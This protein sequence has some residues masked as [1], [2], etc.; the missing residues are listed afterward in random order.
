VST[1]YIDKASRAAAAA[2]RAW[3]GPA[4]RIVALTPGDATNIEVA[5][6]FAGTMRTDE[7]ECVSLASYRQAGP[8]AVAA[9]DALLSR[10]PAFAAMNDRLGRGTLRL[11]LIKRC[12]SEIQAHL[13]RMLAAKALAGNEARLAIMRPTMLRPDSIAGAV[14]GLAVRHYQPFLHSFRWRLNAAR[15]LGGV[16]L[17][18]TRRR[19]ARSRGATEIL[20]PGR[21]AV[22]V[23][24]EDVLSHDRT[25]R[26]QPHWLTPENAD[27]Q[28]LR[29]FILPTTESLDGAG[30]RELEALGAHPLS[31]S[32]LGALESRKTAAERAIG[33]C[34]WQARR[35]LLSPHSEVVTSSAHVLALLDQAK[36]IVRCIQQLGIGCLVA[37]DPHLVQA[38]AMAVAAELTGVPLLGYQYSNLAQF[39]PPMCGTAD[40][41]LLFAEGFEPVWNRLGVRPKK[42]APNGYPYDGAFARV[43]NR[44]LALRD[45]LRARGANTIVCYFD[46]SVQHDRFGIFNP[47][48]QRREIFALLAKVMAEPDWGLVVKSQ[49]EFNSPSRLF[50][51]DP[52]L[53]QA[54]ATGRYV[55]LRRGEHRNVVFP[56]EAAM[57]ADI[58]I[59]HMVGATAPLEAALAGVRSIM[60]DGFNQVRHRRELYAQ[61]P[62]VYPNVE[63]AITAIERWRTGDPAA[64]N[65]GDWTPILDEM[66]AF[67]D[68]KSAERMH[69]MILELAGQ[70]PSFS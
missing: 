57:A 48:S 58:A 30:S 65:V 19:T 16:T 3:A 60:L 2:A 62:I 44:S 23:T 67:R 32:Q 50:A 10:E 45:E 25:V 61:A 33:E 53:E 66:D 52:M 14:K 69:Q 63:S 68:G 31:H 43:R 26:A 17:R 28:G 6:F 35:L 34:E 21:A 22:L 20:H 11:F 42:F 9:T 24:H 54:K 27:P 51:G 8:V 64:A 39:S 5:S 36:L 47:E 37:G 49:F 12:W 40:K 55:E 70:R 56:A 46:E 7:E 41:F 18:A 13:V 1:V 15:T 4:A 38:D 59:G 29:V